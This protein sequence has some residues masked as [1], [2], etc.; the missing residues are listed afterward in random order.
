M[1]LQGF[2]WGLVSIST[3]ILA[4]MCMMFGVERIEVD[5]VLFFV[6]SVSFVGQI[7]LVLSLKFFDA[8]D[9]GS[10]NG[11]GGNHNNNGSNNVDEN[12]ENDEEE[13]FPWYDID[14]LDDRSPPIRREGLV[15]LFMVISALCGLFCVEILLDRYRSARNNHPS[16][17]SCVLYEQNWSLPNPSHSVMRDRCNHLSAANHVLFCIET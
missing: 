15:S 12:G 5:G 14:Q 3:F 7:L 8:S 9:S 16:L 4:P 1:V 17:N 13:D 6:G 2:G 10:N 11:N